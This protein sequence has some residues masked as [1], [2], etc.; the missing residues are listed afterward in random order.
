MLSHRCN[1][2]DAAAWAAGAWCAM[3]VVPVHRQQ[4]IQHVLWAGC[5]SVRRCS[6][7]ALLSYGVPPLGLQ[8]LCP[9]SR[10]LPLQASK[11][12]L[13]QK[14]FVLAQLAA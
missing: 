11:C 5:Q 2:S 6:K 9:S 1:H 8:C 7:N 13:R 12:A 3:L 10:C 4:N 14:L